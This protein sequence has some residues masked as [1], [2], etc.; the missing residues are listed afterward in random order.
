MK[1]Y[2]L[3]LV[4][5][6]AAVALALAALSGC[7][8]TSPTYHEFVMRGQILSVEGSTTTVCIGERDGAAVGQVLEIVRHVRKPGA[9]K[10]KSPAFRREEIGTVRISS[11]YDEHYAV[12][13][14]LEGH[15]VVN[16]TVELERR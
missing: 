7:A 8:T 3:A 13:E 14:V 16:D 1:V 2:K 12:A 11:L 15:P 6:C 10:G 9:P 4:A 5:R